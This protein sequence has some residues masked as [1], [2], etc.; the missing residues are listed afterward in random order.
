VTAHDFLIGL[1]PLG[2]SELYDE[3]CERLSATATTGSGPVIELLL[4]GLYPRKIKRR[5]A[6]ARSSMARNTVIGA[7]KKRSCSR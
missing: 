2:E 4:E 7:R 3:I 6:A 1:P 5:A